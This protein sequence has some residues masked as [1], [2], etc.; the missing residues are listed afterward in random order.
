MYQAVYAIVYQQCCVSINLYEVCTSQ[1][2]CLAIIHVTLLV[3]ILLL[4]GWATLTFL[5]Y[6]CRRSSMT[7]GFI[8]VFFHVIKRIDIGFFF[9]NKKLLIGYMG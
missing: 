6:L 7:Q 2:V 9:L 3:P 4:D 1:S 8:M 5:V